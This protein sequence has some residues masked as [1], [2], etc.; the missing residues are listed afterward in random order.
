MLSVRWIH[1]INYWFGYCSFSF[2][3]YCCDCGLFSRALWLFHVACTTNQNKRRTTNSCVQTNSMTTKQQREQRRRRQR[4]RCANG[5][6]AKRECDNNSNTHTRRTEQMMKFFVFQ[7]MEKCRLQRNMDKG[8]QNKRNGNVNLPE[9][10]YLRSNWV[11][12]L[13]VFRF[14]VHIEP[15]GG[16]WKR[17]CVCVSRFLCHSAMWMRAAF[18]IHHVF[19][20]TKNLFDHH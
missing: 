3:V 5:H 19:V 6:S 9:K 10:K 8:M 15:A 17:V 11:D 2:V 4:C 18:F 13:G 16:E 1:I 7:Y 12:C 20:R 14:Y